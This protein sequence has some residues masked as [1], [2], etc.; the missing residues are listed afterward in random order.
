MFLIPL[1]T[2]VFFF[3]PEMAPFELGS[4]AAV[5]FYIIR[6]VAAALVTLFALYRRSAS[7]ILLM[8]IQ[9]LLTDGS[10]FVVALNRGEDYLLPL[11]VLTFVIIGPS[12]WG[13]RTLWLAKG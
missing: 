7:M 9:R 8:F 4:G 11:L 13:I 3:D 10:D 6:N 1:S 5:D 12:V 2:V